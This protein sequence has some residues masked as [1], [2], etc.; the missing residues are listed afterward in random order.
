MYEGPAKR[1]FSSIDVP[2]PQITFTSIYKH[3][4]ECAVLETPDT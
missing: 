1:G 3:V 2:G 4:Y